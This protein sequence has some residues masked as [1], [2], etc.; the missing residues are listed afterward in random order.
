MRCEYRGQSYSTLYYTK[1]RT[2]LMH[3]YRNSKMYMTEYFR[4]ELSQ[5]MSVMRNKIRTYIH[6]W[7]DKFEVWKYHM[8]LPMYR[9]ICKIMYYLPNTDHIYQN[10]FLTIEWFLRDISYSCVYPQVNHI[11]CIYKYLMIYFSQIKQNKE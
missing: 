9:W 4:Y 11:D 7:C 10:Y 3:M 8:L 1:L 5:L 2:L 6:K